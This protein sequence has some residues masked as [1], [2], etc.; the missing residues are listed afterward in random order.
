M[1]DES[2]DEKNLPELLD[3][4][5]TEVLQ[6]ALER[7]GDN[8]VVAAQASRFS[9]PL[10]PPDALEHYERIHQGFAE[11]IVSM[12]EREQSHRHSIEG[13]AL[14]GSVA[15]EKRGQVFAFLICTAVVIGSIGLIALGHEVPGLILAGSTLV[16]LAY[17]FIT[18]RRQEDDEEGT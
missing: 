8:L 6:E 7:R 15:A 10:P 4:V 9:G 3:E 13:T 16:G 11:R 12:A 5:P 1:S 17:V 18:G 14:S 2:T